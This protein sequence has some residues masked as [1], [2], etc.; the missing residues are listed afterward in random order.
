MTP[1][2]HQRV[3]ELFD[4]ALERPE[5]DRVAFLEGACSGEPEVFQAAA[6][7]LESQ[8]AAQSFLDKPASGVQ[9]MGRYRVTTELGRGAMGVVY[10]AVD[11]LIGRSVAD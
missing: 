4:A 1:E 8:Q 3:R 7:L 11:P 10:E 9:R 5:T 2:Q 6:R